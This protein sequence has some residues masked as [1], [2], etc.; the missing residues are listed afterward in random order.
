MGLVITF[1][2]VEKGKEPG[3]IRIRMNAGS[4]VS[5]GG[6]IRTGDSRDQFEKIFGQPVYR[7]GDR[8]VYLSNGMRLSVQYLFDRIRSITASY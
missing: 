1:P 3:I 4:P 7:A 8:D 5:P 6:D 2:Q